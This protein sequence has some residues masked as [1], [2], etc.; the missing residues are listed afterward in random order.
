MPFWTKKRFLMNLSH[1]APTRVAW[2]KG[3]SWGAFR[4]HVASEGGS[5]EGGQGK[6]YSAA[7]SFSFSC[8]FFL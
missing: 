7:R 5:K 6:K 1:A 2:A 4:S 8:F 3:E